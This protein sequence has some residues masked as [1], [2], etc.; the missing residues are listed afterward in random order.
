MRNR[1]AWRGDGSGDGCTGKLGF[2]VRGRWLVGGGGGGSSSCFL[3][4]SL[5]AEEEEDSCA[6]D[7]EGAN[8][9]DDSTRNGTCAH[10][11]AAR[12]VAR[13]TTIRVGRVVTRI[14]AASLSGSA[15]GGLGN[16]S[17]SALAG[18]PSTKE[19]ERG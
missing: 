8:S 4:G 7:G 1:G 13:I 19:G 15:V 11:T 2:I 17:R 9:A 14:R 3:V 12:V 10:S 6:N 5:L 16:C 18:W